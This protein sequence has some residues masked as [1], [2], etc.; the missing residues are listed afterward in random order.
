M[1]AAV[2]RFPIHPVRVVRDEGAGDW[3]VLW[4]DW[5][6]SHS[7]FAAALVDAHKIAAAHGERVIVPSSDST[8]GD[9]A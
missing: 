8:T 9:A 4:G 1:T 5:A 7:S 3:L 6:W 2:I